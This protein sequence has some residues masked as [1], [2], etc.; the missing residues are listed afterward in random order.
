MNEDGSARGDC[1]QHYYQPTGPRLA[2]GEDGAGTSTE[3]VYGSQTD[4]IQHYL[5]TVDVPHITSLT[6]AM[7][8]RG[9][10][11]LRASVSTA[12]GARLRVGEL[13]VHRVSHIEGTSS[14]NLLGLA[15]PNGGSVEHGR[16]SVLDTLVDPRVSTWS[17]VFQPDD[18][19]LAL[20]PI[21]C[22]KPHYMPMLAPR[23]F[24]NFLTSFYIVNVV[25]VWVGPSLERLTRV[26]AVPKFCV[27]DTGTTSTYG[28]PRFGAALTQAGYVENSGVLKL[29][30]GMPSSP[31]TLTYT[32]DQLRDPDFPTHSVLEVV[33]GRTLDDYTDIFPDHAGGVLLLGAVMMQGM[34]WEWNLR[35]KKIGVDDLRA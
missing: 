29:Q 7:L 22:F 35:G 31:V 27:V 30:L 16:N 32:A 18:G 21:P 19:W 24:S 20:G 5:D 13:V 10:S 9:P 23:A 33:P 11:S 14:S 17:A 15:R 12:S 25:G 3:M 8:A 6:C 4:T 28:S 2:P 34:Y 26:N 1:S